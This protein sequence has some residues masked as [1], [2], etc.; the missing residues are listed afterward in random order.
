MGRTL[1]AYGV[2]GPIPAKVRCGYPSG[3]PQKQRPGAVETLNRSKGGHESIALI[4][5][6]KADGAYL[7]SGG[8]A[9]ELGVSRFAVPPRWLIDTQLFG[10]C[11]DWRFMK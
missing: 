4:D 9:Y 1:P 3:I 8:S 11:C 6:L 5:L 2:A 7:S 10:F